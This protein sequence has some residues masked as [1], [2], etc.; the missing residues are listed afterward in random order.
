MKI[1]TQ[2][3]ADALKPAQQLAPTNHAKQ[4]VQCVHLKVDDGLCIEATDLSAFWSHTLDAPYDDLDVVVSARRLY[5]LVS[6]MEGNLTLHQDGPDLHLEGDHSSAT[7]PGLPAHQYPERPTHDVQP[8]LE[9]EPDTLKT[10]HDRVAHAVSDH[11]ARPNLTGIHLTL[12]GTTLRAEATNGGKKMARHETEVA[13]LQRNDWPEGVIV[14]ADFLQLLARQDDDYLEI[15]ATPERLA[16]WGDDVTASTQTIMGQFPDFEREAI[17]HLD[18]ARRY[19]TLDRE[20][21]QEA[22]DYL[23]LLCDDGEGN[24]RIELQLHDDHWELSASSDTHGRGE[25]TVPVDDGEALGF[26]LYLAHDYL[27]EALAALDANTLQV[28]L[29]PHQSESMKIPL[30]EPT[31]REGEFQLVM[32]RRP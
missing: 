25:R 14:D 2:H 17:P 23:S 26:P 21:L 5:R 22:V 4:T 9:V 30:F 24:E 20:T 3:F 8:D 7:L 12:Q 18:D 31:D 10:L 6:K 32:P 19:A 16:A 1:D 15:G 27:G 11:D 28:R 13:G 29:H